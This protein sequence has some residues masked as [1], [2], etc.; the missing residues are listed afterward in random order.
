MS[1]SENA[2]TALEHKRA[3][4]EK[5]LDELDWHLRRMAEI[6]IEMAQLMDS[7][8]EFSSEGIQM[9]MELYKKLQTIR[10]KHEGPRSCSSSNVV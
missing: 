6:P 9:A 2:K 7:F 8:V 1:D 10:A 5:M 3:K 4:I